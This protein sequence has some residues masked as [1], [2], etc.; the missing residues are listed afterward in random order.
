[1]D[2]TEQEQQWAEEH[3][4]PDLDLSQV[5]LTNDEV[6]ELERAAYVAAI[7]N[8]AMLAEAAQV[9]L[10]LGQSDEDRTREAGGIFF[11]ALNCYLMGEWSTWPF[12]I[13]K[14]TPAPRG[15]F[16]GLC[17]GCGGDLRESDRFLGAPWLCYRCGRAF[18]T[19]ALRSDHPVAV[20]E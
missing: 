12:G 1:M 20:N 7:G 15:A 3:Q 14:P 6:D 5:G 19:D 13:A 17:P 10:R 2:I 16:G 8:A 18:S 11:R 9:V 4:V